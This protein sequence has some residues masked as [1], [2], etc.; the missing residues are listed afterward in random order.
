M[1]RIARSWSIRLVC[2]VAVLCAAVPAA[3]DT[4]GSVTCRIEAGEYRVTEAGGGVELNLEGFGVV[5]TPGGPRLPGRIFAIAVP[6]GAVVTGV[7]FQGKAVALP[8]TFTIG[9]AG[10][11]R[12]IGEENP[13]I[14]KR[15]LAEWSATRDSIYSSDQGWPASPVQFV[16]RAGLRKY[17]LADVR[18]APFRYH[19]QSGT[20]YHYPVLEVTVAYTL[21]GGS[22]RM[23]AED[24]VPQMEQT[25]KSVIL[26]Y[27]QAQAWYPETTAP[28]TTR[29]FVLLTTEALS[30]SVTAL[31]NHE[32]AKGR[33]PE[34][35]TVEWIYTNYSGYDEAEQIRNFLRDKYP[36]S[37]WG[38]RD[39][40]LVGHHNE[41]PMRQAWQ[42]VGY[43]KP[44][45]D[46]YY[47]ELSEADAD[48]WDSDGDHR[49]GEDSDNMDFYNEV[50]VGR[51]PWSDN[52]TV[53]SICSKS[54]AFEQNSNPAFKKN[55]LL[56]GSFFWETTDT[57]ELM[58]AV[59]DQPWMAGWT[60]VRMYEQN[61]TAW[62]S[63]PCD[64]PMTHTNVM[65][66]WANGS[67]S[68]VN[69]AG[70]GSPWSSHIMGLGTQA[71]IET[72]DCPQLNDD[73]PSIV[74]ADSCSNSDTDEANLGREM[75]KSGAVGFIGATKVAL[76]SWE[77][78]DPYDGS[79][80]SC[81]YWFSSKLTSGEMTQGEAHQYSLRQNYTNGL[82]DDPEYEVF[83]W[84]LWGNPDL[85]LGET[86]APAGNLVTGAGPGE[87]NPTEV[88]VWNSADVTAGPM[89]SFSA[90]GVN[91][92]G[93]NVAL[94]DIDGD[95]VDEIVTG[96][97]PGAVFGPHVRAFEMDGTPIPAVSF[98]AYGTH[99]FGVNVALGDIDGDGIA[100]IVTGAGPG[101]V[102]GP[103]VRGWNYDGTAVTAMAGVSFFAYGTPKWGVNVACADI[104]ADGRDE[105]ITGAGPGP[106]YG[107]HIRSWD[108]DGTSSPASGVSFLAFSSQL[109]GVNISGGD[110][111]GD[112][113]AEIIAGAGPGAAMGTHIRAFEVQGTAANAIPGVSFFAYGEA[114]YGVRV[115]C[116][117]LD[118][119]GICEII[120]GE[121]PD[122][123][124][125][126]CI[127]GWNFDGGTLV[128][129]P[130]IDFDAYA[131][132]VTHGANAAAARP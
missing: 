91:K 54:V 44:R 17:D 38:I 60:S 111:D 47:A 45:T 20:L 89:V 73:Y 5:G 64:F 22:G 103:H 63:Y 132:G 80:Q 105:I 121:G 124:A 21:A 104:D 97:G 7:S 76:G 25:A 128:Q 77:W 72:G 15:Q 57:A 94:G 46:F 59:W 123:A 34:V 31:V 116:G 36:S 14:R 49:Y 130:G 55:I 90:Y 12:V 33:T 65:D 70:H 71:Y 19:P 23:T 18:V 88:R 120:S 75:L 37:Q 51:I 62:S 86:A 29:D 114:G 129:M 39:V 99:R 27:T 43:G 48:S 10:L 41:V 79:S 56:L 50:N 96:P 32:A 102:F 84:T 118:G 85:G 83:E 119:D 8:G 6:P 107:A 78:D 16:R 28:G 113:T 61:S 127:R 108:V 66:T 81:D 95:E 52:A 24:S 87:N 125:G 26:N 112:G 11:P 3:A 9:P 122:P 30:S 100:E 69:W 53:A 101:S 67:F 4:A 13:Q 68:F 92:Y 82:W 40:L 109:W 106:I 98:Q 2:V 117:D 110:I 1:S 131:S 58:E 93:T 126:S 42:D 74:W 35:V 115:G